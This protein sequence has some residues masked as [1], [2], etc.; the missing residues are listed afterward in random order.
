M[1]GI[2][3]KEMEEAAAAMEAN[4]VFRFAWPATNRSLLVA[5]G[6]PLN[7]LVLERL[8]PSSTRCYIRLT[9]AARD[10]GCDILAT[11]VLAR[12]RPET[13]AALGGMHLLERTRDGLWKLHKLTVEYPNRFDLLDD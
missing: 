8:P 9:A 11:A 10:T 3:K 12:E 1:S 5:V 7:P 6:L 2:G 13:L 4:P